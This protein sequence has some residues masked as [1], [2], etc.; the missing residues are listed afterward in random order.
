MAKQDFQKDKEKILQEIETLLNQQTL[1]ILSAVD[2]RLEK[3]KNEMR[4][5]INNWMNTLDKF[6]KRLTDFNDEFQKMKTR[7]DKIEG[8]LKEKLGASVE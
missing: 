3:A 1:V 6:L 8:I 4:L 7:M 5:E 2:D